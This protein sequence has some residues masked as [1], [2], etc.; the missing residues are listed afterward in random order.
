MIDHETAEDTY[1]WGNL[2]TAYPFEYSL[3]GGEIYLWPRP[4]YAADRSYT[5]RGHRYPTDWISGGENSEVDADPRLHYPLANY[6]VALAYAQQ[7]DQALEDDYMKRWQM[8]VVAAT[9]AIMEPSRQ[10]PMSFGGGR[11]GFRRVT[12]FNIQRP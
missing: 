5:L 6:A 2:S 12:F 3:W 7:E 10:Q 9:Q 1:G 4:N 11:R 8:D